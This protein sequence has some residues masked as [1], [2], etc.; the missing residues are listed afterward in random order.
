MKNRIPKHVG[1]AVNALL[2]Q[3][4]LNLKNLT[5]Q[6]LDQLPEAVKTAVSSLL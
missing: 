1:G 5:R 6:E 2:S 3:H 4:G